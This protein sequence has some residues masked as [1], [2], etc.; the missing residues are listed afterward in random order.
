MSQ[1]H[2]QAMARSPQVISLENELSKRGKTRREMSSKDAIKYFKRVMRDPD[3]QMKI[4]EHGKRCLSLGE[5]AYND[6]VCRDLM[7]YIIAIRTILPVIEDLRR[8]HSD[9]FVVKELAD[10]YEPPVLRATAS[11]PQELS[12]MGRR[13][14]VYDEQSIA[15]ALSKYYERMRNLIDLSKLASQQPSSGSGRYSSPKYDYTPTPQS[16]AGRQILP[17]YGTRSWD[18]IYESPAYPPNLSLKKISPKKIIGSK[19]YQF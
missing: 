14:T 3:L 4:L 15:Q 2:R 6:D 9:Y 11:P 17:G 18:F 7:P 5:N 19:G 12:I 16:T 1:K 10:V 8:Q 13:V